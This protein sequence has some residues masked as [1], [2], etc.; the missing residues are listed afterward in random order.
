MKWKE[1]KSITTAS[2]GMKH[3]Q[4]IYRCPNCGHKS[5]YK[6]KRCWYCKAVFVEK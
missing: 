1:E 4:L 3:I 2:N 6:T 5:E